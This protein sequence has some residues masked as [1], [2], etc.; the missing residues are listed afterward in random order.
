MDPYGN[1]YETTDNT[2]EARE[3]RARLDGYL[4]ARAEHDRKKHRRAARKNRKKHGR[5]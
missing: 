3:D 5:Q 4:R 1:V 2:E